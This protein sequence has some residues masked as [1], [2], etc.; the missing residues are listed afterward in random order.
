MAT[1]GLR[2]LVPR[3]SSM[4]RPLVSVVTDLSEAERGSIDPLH[5]TQPSCLGQRRGLKKSVQ[6]LDTIYP[7]CPAGLHREDGIGVFR[8]ELGTVNHLSWFI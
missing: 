5:H 4:G 7:G 2:S 8:I 6:V 3:V 1:P